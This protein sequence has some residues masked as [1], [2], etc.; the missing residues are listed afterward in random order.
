MGFSDDK[1]VD[2]M[3]WHELR[4]IAT[5]NKEI[6]LCYGLV[7]NL[8]FFLIIDVD[9]KIMKDNALNL[10]TFSLSPPSDTQF[11]RFLSSSLYISSSIS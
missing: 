11:I 5:G 1:V 4:Q 3:N 8:F 2:C 9:T 10:N 7:K 6:E